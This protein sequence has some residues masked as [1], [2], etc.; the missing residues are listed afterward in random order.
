MVM[1][2]EDGRKKMGRMERTRKDGEQIG[3]PG[4]TGWTSRL[5]G[6][7]PNRAGRVP[8]EFGRAAVTTPAGPEVLSVPPEVEG[9]PGHVPPT[10]QFPVE[11]RTEGAGREAH[12]P[13]K[14]LWPSHRNSNR[15][16]E[17]QAT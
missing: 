2:R 13:Q 8:A 9:L 3:G 6:Q 11:T 1:E 12:S 17:N 4:G 15:S 14:H 10:P 7:E 5:D 16:S